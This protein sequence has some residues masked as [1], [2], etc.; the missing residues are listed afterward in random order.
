MFSIFPIKGLD[1]SVA[2]RASSSLSKYVKGRRELVECG[3]ELLVTILGNWR[4]WSQFEDLAINFLNSPLK[5]VGQC[6]WAALIDSL[7]SE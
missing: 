7:D 3:R 1:H 4:T 6:H 2:V 5:E